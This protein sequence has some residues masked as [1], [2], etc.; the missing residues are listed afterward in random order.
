MSNDNTGMTSEKRT[1]GER[2]R[3]AYPA[4]EMEKRWQE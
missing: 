1:D 4:R 3:V 2:T